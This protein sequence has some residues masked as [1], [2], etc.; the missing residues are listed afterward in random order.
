MPSIQPDIPKVP[1]LIQ[2]GA[3]KIAK[4]VEITL[5]TSTYGE[6]IWYVFMVNGA[7]NQLT[8]GVVTTPLTIGIFPHSTQQLT[9][10][11]ASS[12]SLFPGTLC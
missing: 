5:T 7:I 2:C 6:Y 9:K 10:L 1:V 3:P 8:I 4:L 12:T 11:C